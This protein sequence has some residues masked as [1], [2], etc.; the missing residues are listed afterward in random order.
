MIAK[1]LAAVLTAVVLGAA[2]VAC[3]DN[4]ED[5]QEEAIEEMGE[6]DLENASE[7]MEDAN[8]DLMQ[9]DTTELLN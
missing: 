6:G 4:A 7:S 2:A 3:D 8:E 1:R 9:G 5:H